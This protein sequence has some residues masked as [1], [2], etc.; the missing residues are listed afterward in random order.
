M[1]LG[2][3]QFGLCIAERE[4]FLRWDSNYEGFLK[5]NRKSL[6]CIFRSGFNLW[7]RITGISLPETAIQLNLEPWVEWGKAQE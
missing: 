2:N 6:Y 5:H 3:V 1:E 4:P 7:A